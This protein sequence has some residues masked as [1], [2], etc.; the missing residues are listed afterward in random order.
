MSK[1]VFVSAIESLFESNPEVVTPEVRLYFDKQFKVTKV[2]AKDVAK[3]DAIKSAIVAVLST[4]DVAMTREDIA[5]AI[6]DA[7]TLPE[8]YL[9]SDKGDGLAYGSITSFANQLVAAG[10]VS[11]DVV[12]VGKSRKTVYT[13]S[14]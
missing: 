8:E 11:K 10:T 4:S 12:K 14:K 7:G 2:S 6:N 3:A 5:N 9:T 13:V 1:Q